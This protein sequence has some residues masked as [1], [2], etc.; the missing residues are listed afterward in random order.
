MAYPPS[1]PVKFAAQ[2]SAPLDDY[3]TNRMGHH[4][5]WQTCRTTPARVYI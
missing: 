5:A 1:S 2:K 3:V 4:S